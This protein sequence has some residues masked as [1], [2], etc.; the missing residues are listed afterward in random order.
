MRQKNQV[1]LN[2]GAGGAGEARNAATQESE[3][4]AAKACLER[5]AAA[6]PSVEAVVERSN[7]LK[8]LEQ[9][10][11]NKGAPGIDGMTIA[12]L[13]PY[14]KEH[15]PAIRAQL[16]EGSYKPQPVRRVEI[17]KASGGTRALGIPTVLDPFIQ[18][19]TMQVLQAAWDPTFSEA[20][21]GF[22]PGRS[23]HQAVARAQE[24]IASGHGIVVDLDLEKFFDRVNHD[25]LMGVAKR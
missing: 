23:A 16:L 10:Q 3:I 22:R 13:A 15:W 19:A 17:S 25:I 5:P 18:Q 24:L 1:K 20:S 12:K 9:V 4:R 6:G 11:R 2:L 7:L 21:F 8:A 14:L